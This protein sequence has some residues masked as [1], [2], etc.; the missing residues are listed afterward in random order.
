MYD[1]IGRTYASRRRTDPRLESRIAAAIGNDTRVLNVGAGTGSYE[2][3]RSGVVA[4]EPSAVMIAQRS[5]TSAP[6][7]RGIVEA[8]PFRD[9]AFDVVLG[10]LTMHHWTDLAR[11][12]EEC[13]RVARHREV[14]VTWD[15]N[16]AG[17]WLVQEYFPEILALDREIFPSMDTLRTALGELDVRPLPIPHDCTDG[18]LGASWRRPEAYLDPDVRAGISSFMRIGDI[19]A[20]LARLRTDLASGHWDARWG[21]LRSLTELDVGYRI[22]IAG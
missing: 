2:P 4:L 1:T 22:V 9:R 17:F 21:A 3:A 15:P 7:V 14:F 13:A 12:L 20:S 19:T 18:F 11:G 6:A 8:L 5:A 16:S 10:V